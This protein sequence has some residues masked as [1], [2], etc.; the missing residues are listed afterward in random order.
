MNLT[1]TRP[2]FAIMFCCA[3]VGTVAAFQVGDPFKIL[4]FGAFVGMGLL[5]ILAGGRE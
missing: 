3:L 2:L 5:G 1:G 4:G